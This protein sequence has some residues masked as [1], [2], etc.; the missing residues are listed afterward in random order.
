MGEFPHLQTEESVEILSG[1]VSADHVWA[2]QQSDE[3]KHTSLWISAPGKRA[4]FCLIFFVDI[5]SYATLVFKRGFFIFLVFFSF[6]TEVSHAHHPSST[7]SASSGSRGAYYYRGQQT[8]PVSHAFLN[9]DFSEI[10]NAV[11]QMHTMSLGGE[12]ALAKRWGITGVLPVSCLV[13][14]FDANSVGLG[15][16]TVGG[17]FLVLDDKKVSLSLASSLIFPTGDDVTG[18]GGGG[19]GQQLS[20]FGG[21]HFSDW[22]VFLSP[23]ASFVYGTPHEPQTGISLGTSSPRFFKNKMYASV[24]VSS[25]IY[26]TSD[27]FENGSWKVFLEPQLN[28]VVDQKSR[29]T[30]GLSGRIAV[31]DELSR[32]SS[33]TL[34]Q[35]SNAL[36]N[37]VLW[38]VTTSMNYNF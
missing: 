10:D 6:W 28:W 15:D 36:L 11:G 35:T 17:R 38:G 24:S 23:Y 20:A 8:K 34:N 5:I 21:I 27:V 29:V 4:T 30:L 26:I 9:Y 12:W 1:A 25:L 18:L 16:A 22:T 19:F 32:K 2:L 33:V 14:N 13:E 37:D 31:V 7:S 3:V